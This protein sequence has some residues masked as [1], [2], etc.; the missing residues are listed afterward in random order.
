MT[1]IV[2]KCAAFA[3]VAVVI[4]GLIAN[5]AVIRFQVLA[6]AGEILINEEGV[7]ENASNITSLEFDLREAV[8]SSE[9][10][11]AGLEAL[12]ERKAAEQRALTTAQQGSLDK[13]INLL[14]KKD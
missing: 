10:R 7:D 11:A 4:G 9:L 14:L 3:G 12:I 8:S 5:A 2:T 13:I 1:D 6:Q